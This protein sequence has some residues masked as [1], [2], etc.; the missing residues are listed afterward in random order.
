MLSDLMHVVSLPELDYCCQD[1]EMQ[2][3][4]SPHSTSLL[5]LMTVVMI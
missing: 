4:W 3:I 2:A 1:A 5:P